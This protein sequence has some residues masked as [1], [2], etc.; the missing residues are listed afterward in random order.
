M[1]ECFSDRFGLV[2]ASAANRA[3]IDFDEAD[4]VRILC[5]DEIGDTLQIAPIP[6]QITGA[7]DRKVDRPTQTDPV[8]DVVEKQ[9]HTSDFTF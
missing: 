5:L 3:R 6:E 9:S 1:T 7:R 8:S 2:N 4:D